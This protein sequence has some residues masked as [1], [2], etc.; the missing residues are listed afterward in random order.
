MKENIGKVVVFNVGHIDICDVDSL[1]IATHFIDYMRKK[2]DNGGDVVSRKRS[3]MALRKEIEDSTISVDEYLSSPQGKQD[4]LKLMQKHESS[5]MRMSEGLTEE[6]VK[7]IPEGCRKTCREKVEKYLE[8][9][10]GCKIKSLV[11]RLPN[12]TED[13]IKSSLAELIAD[14]KI[15]QKSNDEIEVISA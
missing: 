5:V 4:T 2:V 11:N 12:F 3:E 13:E 15:R 9:K 6:E 8:N 1:L 7:R 14:R 10:S